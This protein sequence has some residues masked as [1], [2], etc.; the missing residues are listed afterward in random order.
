M[1]PPLG[2]PYHER[3]GGGWLLQWAHN[4]NGFG[5][6]SAAGLF[7]VFCFLKLCKRNLLLKIYQRDAEK[8]RGVKAIHLGFAFA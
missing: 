3:A 1:E 2:F 7:F 4:L 8:E 6:I 5:R